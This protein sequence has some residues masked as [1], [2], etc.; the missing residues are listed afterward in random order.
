[1]VDKNSALLN[2][3]PRTG[4]RINT[5]NISTGLI[6]LPRKG[7]GISLALCLVP[8]FA[9]AGVY[10]YAHLHPHFTAR[11]LPANAR[12]VATLLSE[13]NVKF[14]QGDSSG[15]IELY[16]K[17][18]SLA[19]KIG[20]KDLE[21]RA[22]V[23]ISGCQ[24]GLFAY[25]EALK[26]AQK[27]RQLG[28]EAADNDVVGSAWTNQSTVFS[29]LGDFESARNAA[30]NAV[31]YLGD[32]ARLDLLVNALLAQ[33]NLL[34]NQAASGEL[35]RVY[36]KAASLA[37]EA[38]N[39]H[40]GAQEAVW[41]SYGT[42]LLL[43]GHLAE[44]RE[45][46]EK[47]QTI[48]ATDND[49]DYL[50]ITREHLAELE[51]RQQRPDFQKAQAFIQKAFTLPS[52]TFQTSPQYYPIHIRAR[53]LL[54]LGHTS[55]ALEEF[56]RAVDSANQWRRNALPG[57]STNTRTVAQLQE[58]YGDYA[59][60]AAQIG[61]AQHNGALQTRALEILAD[62]RAASLREQL[63]RSYAQDFRL[64]PEYFQLLTNIEALQAR[65]TLG[66]HRPEDEANLAKARVALSDLE[67]RIGLALNND[68]EYPEKNSRQISLTDVQ[69]RLGGQDLLLSF[70]LGKN[71]FL[72]AV[73]RDRIMLYSLPPE[74]EIKRGIQNFVSS[75]HEQS[76][77]S[78]GVALAKN[79]FGQLPPALWHKR[80][81]LITADGALLGNLPFAA[82][83][84]LNGKSPF[85]Q[86]QTIRFVPSE[87]LML[88]PAS[89]PP[90]PR[91]VGV[92]DPIYNRADARGVRSSLG[93]P[94]RPVVSSITLGRLVG[95]DREIRSSATSAGL[96]KVELLEG[97]EANGSALR[98]ALT[99]PAEIVHFAVHVVSP[100]GHPEEAAVALSLTPE[101]IPELLT[102]EAVAAF[103][104][105][106]SL[107][108]L[109]GCTSGQG[110]ALPGAGIIGLS[111]AWLLAGATAVMVSAWPT[112]DD[113]GPF[114]TS[115]YSHLRANV[116][117]SLAERAAAALQ[118]AQLDMLRGGNGRQSHSPWATY[119]IISKE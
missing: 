60:L 106:G 74:A 88:S 38:A 23:R 113:S 31:S 40:P 66:Q 112:P 3:A 104:V 94:Y 63:A 42:S 36:L 97:P 8:A 75:G 13:A 17:A 101:R 46:L 12:P 20:N 47:A 9:I 64:P 110:Q 59:E 45:P 11:P 41:D 80:N 96:P 87:Y 73:T 49:L 24:I 56:Q 53:I 4:G 78:S 37:K 102:P 33:G 27:G 51:L 44:A 58:V 5:E 86:A 105:P 108:V 26:T 7:F 19:A 22:L 100:E 2:N 39:E 119:S 83:P 55:E 107:I 92:G 95:S 18:A 84:S 72:W 93:Q 1:M 62:N 21:A 71:S 34:T 28:E 109:S 103:R 67:N 15:A 77:E 65:V 52:P 14:H 68:S 79:L 48:E 6:L 50:A 81:W 115:F 10:C 54:G 32:S 61:L 16:T 35:K 25:N 70:Y 114:F 99:Q 43:D 117:G 82:L 116:S 76:S 91:F 30:A 29:Q 69:S 89:K 85:I 111:R 118:Q 98:R 90:E 57:D